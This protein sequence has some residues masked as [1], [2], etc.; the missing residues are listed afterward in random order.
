LS[1]AEYDGA[2]LRSDGG[3]RE[4]ILGGGGGED[5][6][7]DIDLE[8]HEC[9]R[10]DQRD[11]NSGAAC[12]PHYT[13]GPT[14]GDRLPSALVQLQ[15]PGGEYRSH[16]LS[17]LQAVDSGYYAIGKIPRRGQVGKS[18]QLGR[19]G[20]EF[21]G[22]IVLDHGFLTCELRGPNA[23]SFSISSEFCS[24]KQRVI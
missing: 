24:Q 22:E 16:S 5:R 11:A 3:N 9:R 6:G 21:F 7:Q 8:E 18:L 4:G 12:R 1:R 10:D 19:N 2:D 13:H 23:G 14:H 20:D 15:M 17:G